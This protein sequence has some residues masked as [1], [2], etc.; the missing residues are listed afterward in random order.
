MSGALFASGCETGALFFSDVAQQVLLAQ[1]PGRHAFSLDTFDKMQV[2]AETAA[3]AANTAAMS[4]IEIVSR[5]S[6]ELIITHVRPRVE[7]TRSFG[8]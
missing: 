7:P 3:G 6:M 8:G 4:A 1:Q 5:A 2:R